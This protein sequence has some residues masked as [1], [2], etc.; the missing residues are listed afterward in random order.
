MGLVTFN[1]SNI[2][3]KDTFLNLIN[4]IVQFFSGLV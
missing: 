1:P 4:D 3:I 2:S